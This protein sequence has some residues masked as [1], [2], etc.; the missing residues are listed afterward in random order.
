MSE[1]DAYEPGVPCWVESIQ[2]DPEA[3]MAFYRGVFGWEFEGPGRMPGDPPGA[4]YVARVRGREVAGVASL[5]P[6]A[7]GPAW[8][9]H[10]RVA[11]A[12]ETAERARD[13]GG[14]V[15]AAPFDVAPA[16]RMAV[17]ADPAG[18]VFCAWQ[19]R[20]R[21]GAQLVNEPAAW[22]MSQ[23]ATPDPAGAAAF[24]GAVFGWTTETF[25]LGETT[26]TMF[27][28]PGYVG[29]EPQQPVS[30]EVVAT[31]APAEEGAPARWSVDFWVHDVDAAAERAAA[32]GGAALVPPFDFPIG[33]S[34]VLADPSGLAFSVSRMTGTPG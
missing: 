30:R 21:Q 5:P 2:P 29:G 23:L 27:R 3:A 18:A 20:S 34:A 19:P 1:R 15:V 9:T 32:G 33:R 8:Q 14:Q 24:Y 12:E 13:A 26:I 7:P 31:M 6:A 28:L 25:A 17:L 4:Y 22:S 10:V 16:G 11:D